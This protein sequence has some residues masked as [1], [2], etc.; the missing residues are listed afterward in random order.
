MVRACASVRAGD[1][2]SRKAKQKKTSSGD[3]RRRTAA[4]VMLKLQRRQRAEEEAQ[5]GECR[6]QEAQG[7]RSP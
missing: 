5:R 7:G 2:P 3:G 4:Q 6:W 1:V